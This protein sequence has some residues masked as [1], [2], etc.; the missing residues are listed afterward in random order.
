MTKGNIAKGITVI[1]KYETYFKM[2][3]HYHIPKEFFEKF[4]T[5]RDLYNLLTA[6]R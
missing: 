2:E 6:D 4:E 3:Q 5:K 1:L